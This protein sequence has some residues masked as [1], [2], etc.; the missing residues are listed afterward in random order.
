M[1]TCE[2]LAPLQRY[3]FYVARRRDGGSCADII[4][5]LTRAEDT[6]IVNQREVAD[7]LGSIR[8]Y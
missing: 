6:C 1:P 4:D 2:T 5:V 7:V 3:C 8:P